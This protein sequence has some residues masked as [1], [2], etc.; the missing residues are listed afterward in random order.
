MRST[1]INPKR[2]PRKLKKEIVKKFGKLG[3]FL[4]L[5]GKESIDPKIIIRYINKTISIKISDIS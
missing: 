2:I 1:K 5:C 3:F 4:L